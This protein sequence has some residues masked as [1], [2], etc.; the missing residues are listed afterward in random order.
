MGGVDVQPDPG[1]P[2]V[3]IAKVTGKLDHV[4]GVRLWSAATDRLDAATPSLIVD[5]THVEPLTS[6]GIGTFARLY[7]RVQSLG[8]RMAIFGASPRARTTIEAVLL[9]EILG[10]SDSLE[11]A[12]G[13][14]TS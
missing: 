14:V 1:A 6:A 10:L 4:G 12:R 13:K 7:H 2:G 8:G 3:V 5:I 11:E 9:A